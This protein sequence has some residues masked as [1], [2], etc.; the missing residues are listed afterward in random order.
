MS[1]I[2]GVDVSSYQSETYNI[3]GQS[4][5]IVKATESTTYKNPKYAGQVAHA[6]NAGLVVGHYHYARG[7]NSDAEVAYFK[8]YA[9][10]AAGDIIAMDWEQ[11]EVTAAARDEFLHKMKATFPHNRVVLYCNVEY[12]TTR[13]T[14]HYAADGLWVADYSHAA[15]KPNIKQ[16][17]VFNQYSSA[18]GLD[19]SVAIFTS[20]SALVTWAKGLE[21]IAKPVPVAS[22]TYAYR[23]AHNPFVKPKLAIDGGFGAR[24]ARA[25]QYVTGAAVDGNW[26]TTSVRALQ[27]MLGVSVDGQAGTRT[28]EALQRKVGAAPDGNWGKLT[29]EAV[30]RALN[31][32]KLS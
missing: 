6:R 23:A 2:S 14:E 17:W 24:T 29:T 10:V 5:A 12:W 4:F 21:T 1:Y 28:V 25:L 3:S 9:K 31:A 16:A 30:Q 27:K 32:G 19:H 11:S 20:K 13:D 26:G 8:A 15:G 18:N 22:D 7:T